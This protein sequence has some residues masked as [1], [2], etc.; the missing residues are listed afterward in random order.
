MK[1]NIPAIGTLLA[2]S[3]AGYGCSEEPENGLTD[4]EA[5]SVA[6][7]SLDSVGQDAQKATAEALE[8]AKMAVIASKLAVCSEVQKDKEAAAQMAS[9]AE[10]AAIKA[11][12]DIKIANAELGEAID[13]NALKAEK[14]AEIAV[15]ETRNAAQK[16]VESVETGVQSDLAAAKAAALDAQKAAIKAATA[17]ADASKAAAAAAKE[18]WQKD[19]AETSQ[20]G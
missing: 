8:S 18:S 14:L 2:V 19:M 13:E 10:A 17:A 7:E 20:D 15:T 6:R 9:N 5:A 16:T 3:I 11:Q 12:T 1:I 4:T